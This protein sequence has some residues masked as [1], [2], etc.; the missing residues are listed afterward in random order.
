MSEIITTSSSTG[1]DIETSGDP[2]GQIQIADE[3]IAA[4][5]STAVLETEGVASM[6]SYFS[7]DI[8]GRLSRKKATKGI[9]LRTADGKVNISVEIVVQSGVKIQEV[10]K[11]V[12]Q[13][14]KAAVETM[15]GFTTDEINVH[16]TGLVA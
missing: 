10:A 9:T 13:K 3:V 4:I 6:A 12:Q 8:A 1:I 14:V 2:S 15:T 11:D 7:G 5:A 16:V